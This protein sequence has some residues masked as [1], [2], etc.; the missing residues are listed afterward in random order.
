[1][2]EVQIMATTLILDNQFVRLAD[3]GTGVVGHID[4]DGQRH[5]VH[6]TVTPT[7][8]RTVTP[9]QYCARD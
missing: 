4:I 8:P 1:M 7:G 2:P 6:V 3:D 9:A 5:I